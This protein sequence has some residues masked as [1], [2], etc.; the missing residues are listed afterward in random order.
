MQ[1]P[2]L[3][4][5][6]K[7]NAYQQQ[8]HKLVG[9]SSGS[10]NAPES[11]SLPLLSSSPKTTAY[12]SADEGEDYYIDPV[13]F[14]RDDAISETLQQRKS[15]LPIQT[16]SVHFKSGSANKPSD[17]I[18]LPDPPT[19]SQQEWGV[20]RGR[21]YTQDCDEDYEPVYDEISEH[22]L[23]LR[24]PRPRPESSSSSD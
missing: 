9:G 7:L 14:Q 24:M 15:P 21:D 5:K 12:E 18:Q 13:C 22:T 6:P 8:K 3:K 10:S 19:H 20:V 2:P 16:D 23:L 17:H 1:K 4:P 11:S